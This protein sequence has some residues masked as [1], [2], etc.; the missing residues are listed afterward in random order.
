MGFIRFTV[1]LV[2]FNG[3]TRM[4]GWLKGIG[5]KRKAGRSWPMTAWRILRAKFDSAQ[6][7]ADNSLLR[8][9]YTGDPYADTPAWLAPNGGDTGY[10]EAVNGW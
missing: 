5:G 2:A 8:L 6:T 9:E 7:T 1:S 4:F 3:R 10:V